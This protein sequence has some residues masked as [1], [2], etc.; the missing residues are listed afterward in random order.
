MQD[1]K[2][3]EGG[4]A[5]N[6]FPIML[7]VV[8]GLVLLGVVTRPTAQEPTHAEAPQGPRLHF[9]AEGP[10]VVAEL[11]GGSSVRMPSGQVVALPEGTTLLVDQ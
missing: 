10:R 9:Q 6:P 8:A 1:G 11:P 2:T 4:G 7:A 5:A 3:H